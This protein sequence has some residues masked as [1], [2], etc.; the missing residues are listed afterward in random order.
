MGKGCGQAMLR[1]DRAGSVRAS[2][3]LQRS[4]RTA[5]ETRMSRVPVLPFAA[6]PSLPT[7]CSPRS[8]SSSLRCLRAAH[9]KSRAH[10]ETRRQQPCCNGRGE[11][12]GRARAGQP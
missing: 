9:A 6:A 5:K 7:A 3:C 11:G 1:T 10:C 12:E 8:R 2:G 4:R